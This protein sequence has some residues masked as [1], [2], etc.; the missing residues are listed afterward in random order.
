LIQAWQ[1]LLCW[2]VT[3]AINTTTY[4]KLYYKT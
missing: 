1:T 2:R 4:I 3:A